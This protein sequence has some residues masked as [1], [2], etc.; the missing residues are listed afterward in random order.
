MVGR[1]VGCAIPEQQVEAAV[2]RRDRLQG[3]EVGARR[4]RAE[5]EVGHQRAP[6]SCECFRAAE[7]NVGDRGH[8]PIARHLQPAAAGLQIAAAI[9]GLIP[10]EEARRR[11]R[12]RVELVA[13]AGKH[14]APARMR[15]D[16]DGDQAHARSLS[17]AR[18]AADSAAQASAF[19]MNER[20]ACAGL[21]E[22]RRST[23]IAAR[24]EPN[25]GATW[26]SN[27]RAAVPPF[28]AMTR[29]PT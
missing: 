1:V 23:R 2:F 6:R 28:K 25:A 5:D 26:R 11:G 9:G 8:A 4:R 3:V 15:V 12:A 14:E 24:R 27:S 17:C 10:I 18:K 20:A 7:A 21:V 29:R 19:S 22:G 16:G 13:V